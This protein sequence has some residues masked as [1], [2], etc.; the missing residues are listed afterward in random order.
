MILQKLFKNYKTLLTVAITCIYGDINRVKMKNNLRL[1]S[2]CCN[3][4]F[5]ILRL[6]GHSS[7]CHINI[8]QCPVF[9]SYK[10]KTIN[11]LFCTTV[12]SLMMTQSGLKQVAAGVLCYRCASLDDGDTF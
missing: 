8:S 5:H 12:C 11:H 1:L 2:K 7:I 4:M 10:Q 9:N 3:S 6:S